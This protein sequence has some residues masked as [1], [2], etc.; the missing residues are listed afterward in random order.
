[1]LERIPFGAVGTKVQEMGAVNN[2]D[3]VCCGSEKTPPCGPQGIRIAQFR[4]SPFLPCSNPRRP[5]TYDT[6]VRTSTSA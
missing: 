4:F 1:M 2:G 6:A 5:D 3:E